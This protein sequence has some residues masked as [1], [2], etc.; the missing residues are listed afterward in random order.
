MVPPNDSL[1]TGP[2]RPSRAPL[3]VVAVVLALAGALFL[4]RLTRG[5]AD[6]GPPATGP[7]SSATSSGSTGST[8][9]TGPTTSG[10]TTAV[11]APPACAF[12][13]EP[14]RFDG[15]GDWPRTLL[16]TTFRLG[17][18]YVP[19][20][21]VPAGGSFGPGFEVRA[22]A[23]DDLAALAE[24]AEAAGAPLDLIAAY[25]SYEEQADLFERRVQEQGEDFALA[26]VARPGHSEHQLGTAVDFKTPGAGDVDADWA[27]SAQ[28]VWL[29]GHAWEYGFVLSY[30]KDATP[31]TCYTFEPWHFRYV[32]RDLAAS[33]HASGLTLREYLWSWQAT[34]T[35]PS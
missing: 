27:D 13:D 10:G 19:P 22:V 17:E 21:L 20:D 26:H 9:P 7:S 33:V 16:D 30:P 23:A 5:D 3:L 31:V 24:A 11:E 15:V 34:G 35:A 6:P 29:A 25:R 32:G 28:G 1:P 14:T 2:R 18:Q 4:V 12:G 8:E